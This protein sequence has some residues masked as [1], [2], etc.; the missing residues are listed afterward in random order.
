MRAPSTRQ[1]IVRC[2]Q[3]GMESLN[4]AG[5]NYELGE[6]NSGRDLLWARS[7]LGEI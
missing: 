2:Q 1:W 6:I 5:Q 4:Y 3:E 7:I